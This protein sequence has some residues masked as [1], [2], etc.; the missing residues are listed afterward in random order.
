MDAVDEQLLAMHADVIILFSIAK[1]YQVH[2]SIYVDMIILAEIFSFPH[3]SSTAHS[4][5]SP[6]YF[7]PERE[8]RAF[9]PLHWARSFLR[10]DARRPSRP[11]HPLQVAAGR[12]RLPA[13]HPNDR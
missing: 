10:V 11:L 1:R 12:I 3:N 2:V 5:R 8:R 9:L 4:Q 13:G 6:F 7:G